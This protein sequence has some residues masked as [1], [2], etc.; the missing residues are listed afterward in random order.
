MR[1]SIVCAVAIALL[2]LSSEVGASESTASA[3]HDLKVEV[4]K[5]AEEARQAERHWFEREWTGYRDDPKAFAEA[6]RFPYGYYW[7]VQLGAC[8]ESLQDVAEIERRA[9]TLRREIDI[10]RAAAGAEQRR[11]DF[12][13]ALSDLDRI[14]ERMKRRK[15]ECRS[16][17]MVFAY[18]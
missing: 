8:T 13:G 7:T 14:N 6:M 15:E 16:R 12:A 2:L 10:A 18:D 17:R 11:D 3:P 1:S 5:L 4:A 9:A